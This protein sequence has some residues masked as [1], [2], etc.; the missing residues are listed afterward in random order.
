METETTTIETGE[1]TTETGATTINK[2][3]TVTPLLPPGSEPPLPMLKTGLAMRSTLDAMEPSAYPRPTFVQTEK[4]NP[5]ISLLEAK[6]IGFHGLVTR[7]LYEMPV[8]I[9]LPAETI[10]VKCAWTW[11][12]LRARLNKTLFLV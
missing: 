9:G 5:V 3:E 4:T 10:A 8:G 12:V 6:A 7:P 2:P 1:T 11:L